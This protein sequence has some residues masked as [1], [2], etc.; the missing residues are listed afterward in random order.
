MIVKV[1]FLSLIVSDAVQNPPE[2]CTT[3]MHYCF[4]SVF[5]CFF[6]CAAW[7]DFTTDTFVVQPPSCRRTIGDSWISSTSYWISVFPLTFS[8]SVQYS[9]KRSKWFQADTQD[10]CSMFQDY[11]LNFSVFTV[12]GQRLWE[13]QRPQ[14]VDLNSLYFQFCIMFS[15]VLRLTPIG[16]ERTRVGEVE[17]E[18]SV[19]CVVWE[20]AGG[21]RFTVVG[22]AEGRRERLFKT[23]TQRLLLP[24]TLSATASHRQSPSARREMYPTTATV[25]LHKYH[26]V[27]K[28][29]RFVMLSSIKKE[30]ETSKVQMNRR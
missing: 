1:I 16:C 18:R 13:R 29:V 21:Y 24:D 26:K 17:G 23:P 19:C 8:P 27:Q 10:F 22:L 7:I 11:K 28:L 4:C 5:S 15:T 6:S 20:M 3:R 9:E 30:K 2:K 12:T 25:S 14:C